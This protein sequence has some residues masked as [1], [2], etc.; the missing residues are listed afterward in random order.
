MRQ[1]EYTWLRT[2][3]HSY[4][5]F[6]AVTRDALVYAARSLSLNISDDQQSQLMNAC[7]QLKPWPDA[8][9]ALKSLKQAGFRLAFLSNFSARMLDSNIRN[10]N[11]DG[12]FEQVLGTDR[13]KTYEPD[14][15][16][17]QMAV[18]AF[19]LK[20]EEIAVVAGAGWDAAGARL[21]GYKTAWI[22]RTN[23]PA[24]ELGVGPD[25]VFGDLSGLPGFVANPPVHI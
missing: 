4:A 15:M 6:W 13:L 8:L 19:G 16:A 25:A 9:P 7:L 18:D 2:A 12:I 17:D 3:S 22:N 10:S 1:F 21:F 20:R 11:L 14:P 5:D 23:Q 24:E